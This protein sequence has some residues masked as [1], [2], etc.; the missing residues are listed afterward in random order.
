MT[1]LMIASSGTYHDNPMFGACAGDVRNA[2]IRPSSAAP[3]RTARRGHGDGM[4]VGRTEAAVLVAGGVAHDAGGWPGSGPRRLLGRSLHLVDDLVASL[5]WTV[6][7]DGRLGHASIDAT[8]EMW[9]SVPQCK[10]LRG[11]SHSMGRTSRCG[12]AAAR[13]I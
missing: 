12:I 6:G 9:A 7:R 11:P 10:I 13:H 1:F 3:A 5:R 4:A 2:S 8:M